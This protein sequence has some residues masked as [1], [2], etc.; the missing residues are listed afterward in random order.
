MNLAL[1]DEQMFWAAIFFPRWRV[2]ANGDDFS[3][4]SDRGYYAKFSHVAIS[5]VC[6]IIW[7]SIEENAVDPS[8]LQFRGGHAVRSL[9]KVTIPKADF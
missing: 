9:R 8:C 5:G 2:A 7:S 1:S 4:T 3:F 6:R